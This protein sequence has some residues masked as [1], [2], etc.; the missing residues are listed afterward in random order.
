MLPEHGFCVVHDALV[1]VIVGVGEEDVPVLGQGVG[2][3]GEPVVLTGDE[4]AICS[5]M[6]A[7]LVVSTV[8][9]SKRQGRKKN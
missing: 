4:A 9:V 5:L 6:D 1:G 8:T 3:D 2:V 7:R